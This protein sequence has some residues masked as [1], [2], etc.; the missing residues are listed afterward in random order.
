MEVDDEEYEVPSSS[1]K[2]EKKRFEVKKVSLVEWGA[3]SAFFFFR[4]SLPWKISLIRSL[5]LFPALPPFCAVR[6]VECRGS[7][8]LG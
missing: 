3:Q 6:S 5:C 7:M 4:R 2:G 8:G 1:N